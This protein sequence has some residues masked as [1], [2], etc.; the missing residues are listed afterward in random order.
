MSFKRLAHRLINSIV[1]KTG[2]LRFNTT[3]VYIPTAREYI[4]ESGVYKSVTAGSVLLSQG[5]TTAAQ[6]NGNFC[7]FFLQW[8]GHFSPVLNR[9][10][11]LYSPHSLLAQRPK[12]HTTFCGA[13][14]CL[15][16][17]L[18]YHSW[19]DATASRR[20]ATTLMNADDNSLT[21]QLI[22][23]STRTSLYLTSRCHHSQR[24]WNARCS[25]ASSNHWFMITSFRE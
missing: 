23:D 6:R 2:V 14:Q 25:T 10:P 7:C 18:N 9:M 4:A 12:H 19:T 21:K 1:L 8:N 16:G 3:G 20:L 24:N 5:C 22:R 17:V 13:I 15:L 11:A